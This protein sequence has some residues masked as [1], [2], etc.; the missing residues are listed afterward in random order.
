[1]QRIERITVPELHERMEADDRLQLLDVRDESEWRAG[2]IPDSLH[3]PYHD[4]DALPPSIDPARPVAARV[5]VRAPQRG[6]RQPPPTPRRRRGAA[7]G[8]RRGGDVAR[9]GW[10]IE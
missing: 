1:M 4:I 2:H 3:V 8:R 10:P 9:A 5:R 6:C 7:R